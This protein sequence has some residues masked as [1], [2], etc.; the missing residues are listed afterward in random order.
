M[1]ATVSSCFRKSRNSKEL[2]YV[3]FVSINNTENFFYGFQTRCVFEYFCPFFAQTITMYIPQNN[4]PGWYYYYSLNCSTCQVALKRYIISMYIAVKN[5]V[6]V[7]DFFVPGC[8]LLNF[9]IRLEFNF[10]LFKLKYIF[11]IFVCTI[12]GTLHSVNTPY[13]VEQD[14]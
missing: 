5:T 6:I 10:V 3:C 1:F 13:H 12:N 11:V 7:T 14:C 4:I 8:K 2:V 9:K